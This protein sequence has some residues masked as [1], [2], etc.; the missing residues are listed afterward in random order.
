MSAPLL[1]APS[2]QG[3]MRSHDE[4]PRSSDWFQAQSGN[5]V[6]PPPNSSRTRTSHSRARYAPH[7]KLSSAPARFRPT[8]PREETTSLEARPPEPSIPAHPPSPHTR[9]HIS[10]PALPPLRRTP[11]FSQ[12]I[13]G[14]AA[15]APFCKLHTT[16]DLSYGTNLS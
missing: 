9:P 15:S 3:T 7:A 13:P 16:P 10:D 2:P 5:A 14:T 8:P 4:L 11:R 1:S 6:L 12:A